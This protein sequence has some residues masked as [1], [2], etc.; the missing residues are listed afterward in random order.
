MIKIALLGLF[1]ALYFGLH[2]LLASR[3]IK[4]IIQNKLKISQRQYR[5]FYNI[6]SVFGLIGILIF[7]AT[8]DYPKFFKSTGIIRYL[9]LM[10]AT[11]GIII[12]KKAFGEYDI[13]E[14]IGLKSDDQSGLHLRKKGI[15]SYIRHPI[16]AGIILIICGLFLYSPDPASLTTTACVFVYLYIGIKLEEKK[17]LLEYGE[18][19]LEYKKKVPALFPKIF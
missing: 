11:F 16:Y 10:L 19:Y 13:R 15:L 14:F 17:L 4:R 18:K 3:N 12:L 1:W 9:S 7:Y 8:L 5:V 2:S 6:I